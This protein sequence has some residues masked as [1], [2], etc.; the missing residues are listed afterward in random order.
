MKF[1]EVSFYEKPRER[2][3]EVGV[4][5]LTNNE[6]LCLLLRC[7]TQN[8]DVI[9]LSND[10]LN[11]INSFDDLKDLTLTE[12]LSLKGIGLSKATIILAA[13]E[14]GKR[15]NQKMID[16]TKLMQPVDVYNHFH[17]LMAKFTQEHL[18]CLYLDTKG[19]MIDYRLIGIGT[20]NNVSI[21]LKEIFKWAFK[22]KATA[23]ILVHNHPSGDETPSV[24][25]LKL[26]EEI[27]KQA[28]LLKF[29]LLDHIIIGNYYHSMKQSNHLF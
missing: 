11:L 28:R 25:D 26:T 20:I 22:F 6:L 15:L 29:I 27:A 9:D 18:Y 19:K 4:E 24:E 7:G 23:L 1:K 21:D 5:N 13:V 3:V 10:V 16:R 17:A 8:K 2:L 12:L 14:L